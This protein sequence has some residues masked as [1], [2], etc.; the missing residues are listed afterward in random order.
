MTFGEILQINKKRPVSMFI[1]D[2]NKE[3]AVLYL[4]FVLSEHFKSSACGI[5]NCLANT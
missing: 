4:I 2:G 3:L 1:K 5:R